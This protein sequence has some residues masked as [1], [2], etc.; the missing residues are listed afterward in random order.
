MRAARRIAAH[1]AG[2]VRGTSRNGGA[3]AR[4]RRGPRPA[5]VGCLLAAFVALVL[6]GCGGGDET[7]PKADGQPEE[8]VQRS[9]GAAVRLTDADRLRMLM[10]ERA[11]ALEAGD[12]ADYSKTAIGAQRRR[13][14]RAAR[15]ATQLPLRDV[16]LDA[17]VIDDD[18][19]R[20]T[21]R[22]DEA[23]SVAGVRSSFR[24]TYRVSAV[25]TSHGWRVHDVRGTRG[26]PPWRLAEFEQRRTR[27]FVVLAP[28]TVPVDQLLP[29]LEA[30]YERTRAL[31]EGSDLRRRYLVVVA[32]DAAQARALT[33]E[34]RG[35]ETLTAIS[36]AAIVEEGAAR[37]VSKVVS[38]R[39]LVVWPPFAALDAE[40]RQRVITH[41]LTHA[42]LAGET[43]GRTP[44]WLVEG[45][46]LY[47]SDDR[48]ATP[49]NADLGALSEPDAIGRLAGAAQ[50]DAYATSSAAAFAI[51]ERYGRRRLLDLYEAFNDPA[52]EGAPGRR[53]ADRA[54][55]RELRTTLGA[56]EASLG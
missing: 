28:P 18:G 27:H 42:A 32:A 5:L 4:A 29:D 20:A 50:A 38:L 51:A 2:G 24:S 55:R 44:A 22:V 3:R 7:A 48:R 49:A 19:D 46:A 56:I 23:Y 52:L 35:V 37:A 25:R 31:L 12:V 9:D 41:E 15:R 36:D 11:A 45:V 39:L 34:I 53:L 1:V 16:T 8:P 6:A 40:G 33:S 17:E 14:R 26:L 43:S 47:V 13:D 10:N 54:V 21:L 30:G